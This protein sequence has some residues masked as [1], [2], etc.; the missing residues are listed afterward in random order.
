MPWRCCD[1]SMVFA[2]RRSIPRSALP[3]TRSTGT[4]MI[5]MSG[6]NT[7]RSTRRGIGRSLHSSQGFGWQGF[8]VFRT[9]DTGNQ[10][11]PNQFCESP[12]TLSRG[13][14]WVLYANKYPSYDLYVMTDTCIHVDAHRCIC[15]HMY[16]KIC[17]YVF[18]QTYICVK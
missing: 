1:I 10:I 2:P 6:T 15:I 4:S 7:I 18:V 5:W 8:G 14:F 9:G 16:M 3:T 11:R 13:T 12:N 17:K